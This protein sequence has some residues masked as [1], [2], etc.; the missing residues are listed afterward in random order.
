MKDSTDM[1]IN[2]SEMLFSKNMEIFPPE[3]V[4]DCLNDCSII[5]P[6][7]N[8]RINGGAGKANIRINKPKTPNANNKY[9]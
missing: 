4:M 5:P 2:T 8:A 6:R 1:I 7:M 9:R 3:M